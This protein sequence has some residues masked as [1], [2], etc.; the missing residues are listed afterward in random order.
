MEQEETSEHRE[1][2]KEHTERPD[3]YQRL[4]RFAFFLLL[5]SLLVASYFLFKPQLERQAEVEAEK[6]ALLAEYDVM[7]EHQKQLDEELHLLREDPNYLEAKARDRLDLQK[8]GEVIFR[9]QG[10]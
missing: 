5:F 10:L 1:L 6:V 4:G 3:I 8:D 7:L 2:W 9:L